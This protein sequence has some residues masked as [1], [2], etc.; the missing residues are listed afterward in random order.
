M[1]IYAGIDEAGYGPMLGPLCVAAT[2]FMIHDHDDSAPPPDL[3]ER[4]HTAV[5]REKRDAKR[6]IAIDDSKKLKGAKTG[7][8]H[9]LLHLER[10][11]LA[12]GGEVFDLPAHDDAYFTALGATVEDETWMDS[13]TELP[14]AQTADEIRL[15]GGRLR[16][17]LESAGV[18][19][20]LMQCETICPADFNAGVEKFGSKAVVNLSAALRL[21]EAVRKKWPEA[22]PTIVVDRQSGRMRY[23]DE[24][25]MGWPEATIKV[26]SESPEESRYRLEVGTQT[27]DI[28]Y[29]KE[30]EN[31][32]L[33]VALASMVA[34]YTRE[35]AMVRLNR[36]F[37]GHLPELKPTAG[38][39][40]DARRYLQEID[41]V[42]RSFGIERQRLAR[43][44]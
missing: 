34:K 36:F 2:A 6:R 24:M 1:L 32:H 19:I 11:V 21:A 28:R 42:L 4:L 8:A 16:R 35:L 22:D 29:L 13:Q 37:Q 30:A 43:S 38:Y 44:V 20:G 33:P 26:V 23:Y 10:G 18:E 3:W 39:V 14:V 5:G 41:P 12:F 15:L 40:T 17:C 27:L 7:K 25:R 31:H 9:P